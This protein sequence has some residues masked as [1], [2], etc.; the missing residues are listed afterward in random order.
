[1]GAAVD[2]SISKGERHRRAER[3]DAAAQP[4][5]QLL[6]ELGP[7]NSSDRSGSINGQAAKGRE[8]LKNN[9]IAN[10]TSGPGRRHDHLMNNETKTQRIQ[11]NYNIDE[12]AIRREEAYERLA[13]RVAALRARKEAV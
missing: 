4:Y 6:R 8:I 2:N 11:G 10:A 9:D 12:S 5:E 3:R 1:M 7:S 13:I